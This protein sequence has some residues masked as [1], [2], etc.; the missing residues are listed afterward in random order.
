MIPARMIIC[1]AQLFFVSPIGFPRVLE[2]GYRASLIYR[3]RRRRG[4]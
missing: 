3:L 1:E 2:S 4:T